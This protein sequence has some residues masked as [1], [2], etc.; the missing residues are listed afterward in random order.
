MSTKICKNSGISNDTLNK[1][2][3]NKGE[4][5]VGRCNEKLFACDNSCPHKGASLH[6]GYFKNGNLVCYMH[7]YE[8]DVSTGKLIKISEKWT[9]QHPSWKKSK[10]IKMYQIIKKSD[11]L[12]VETKGKHP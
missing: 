9:N 4:I 12:Y 11:Y 7:D 3:I 2:T 5:L 6:R 10:D 1:F 8:F